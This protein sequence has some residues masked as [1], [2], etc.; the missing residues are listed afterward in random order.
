MQAQCKTTNT[1]K[2]LILQTQQKFSFLHFIKLFIDLGHNLKMLG[3]KRSN[4][5]YSKLGCTMRVILVSFLCLCLSLTANAF[6][7]R[8]GPCVCSFHTSY[9]TN[10]HIT[11]QAIKFLS[12]CQNQLLQQ[13]YNFFPPFGSLFVIFTHMVP[14][15]TP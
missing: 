9:Q 5:L 3:V 7:M 11:L 12:S 15:Y 10:A 13:V 6:P 1:I 4:I 8:L 14:I 2:L